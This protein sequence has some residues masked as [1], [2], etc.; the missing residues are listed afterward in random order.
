MLPNL[1]NC[2]LCQ[3]RGLTSAAPRNAATLSRVTPIT[4]HSRF[5]STR[6]RRKP[7]RM[8]LSEHVERPRR[9]GEAKAPPRRMPNSPFG[10]MNQTVPPTMT[11]TKNRNSVSRAQ[12]QRSTPK[13]VRTPE[14]KKETAL[15]RALKMQAMLTPVHYEKRNRIKS[16]IETVTSFKSF[17]LLPSI[18]E[19]IE[20][21]LFAEFDSITPTPIQRLAIPALLDEAPH[22]LAK[23][24]RNEEGEEI[25]DYNFKQFLLA[26]ETGSGKSLAY[27]LPVVDAIK[28]EEEAERIAEAQLAKQKAEE[29]EKRAHEKAF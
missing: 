5:A 19:A 24:P 25:E 15:F 23:K 20:K 22:K 9:Y 11:R 21:T 28:R 3:A 17:R 29:E 7:S 18:Q 26:A 1:S 10:G 13:G 8:T 2:L 4:L 12:L 16:S 6:T 14:P 27:I